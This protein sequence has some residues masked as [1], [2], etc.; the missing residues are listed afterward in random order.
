MVV[1]IDHPEGLFFPSSIFLE[2]QYQK[3]RVSLYYQQCSHMVCGNCTIICIHKKLNCFDIV[4]PGIIHGGFWYTLSC[5]I[6]SSNQ[7]ISSY[8]FGNTKLMI[9]EKVLKIWSTEKLI[10]DSITIEDPSKSERSKWTRN[11][12]TIQATSKMQVKAQLK[13]ELSFANCILQQ[14]ATVYYIFRILTSLIFLVDCL[15]LISS[16]VHFFLIRT[17]RAIKITSMIWRKVQ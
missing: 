6:S 3:K 1:Y 13:I 11:P 4:I 15:F 10:E 12:L 8:I 5:T 9:K 2:D 7:F 17:I 16:E 14:K